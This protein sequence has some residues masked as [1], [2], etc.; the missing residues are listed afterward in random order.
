MPPQ[1]PEDEY[2]D[3]NPDMI[4]DDQDID[5]IGPR[6]KNIKCCHVCLKSIILFK[7]SII[8]IVSTITGIFHFFSSLTIIFVLVPYILSHTLGLAIKNLDLFLNITLILGN[9]LNFVMSLHL[10]TITNKQKRCFKFLYKCCCICNRK[11]S[12]E[13]NAAQTEEEMYVDP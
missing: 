1:N 11:K 9:I 10:L 7:E 5:S 8:I 13:Q 4:L 2:P 12:Q 6:S 3:L